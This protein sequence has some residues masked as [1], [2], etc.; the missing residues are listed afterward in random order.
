MKSSF[1]L[2]SLSP[3]NVSIFGDTM[4]QAQLE[5]TSRA[6]RWAAWLEYEGFR[7]LIS[8]GDSTE[9]F[10]KKHCDL[11]TSVPYEQVRAGGQ[12]WQGE[13]AEGEDV[14][15][16]L[17]DLQ[18]TLLYERQLRDETNYFLQYTFFAI[19]PK[20]FNWL[21]YGAKKLFATIL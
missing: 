1:W 7:T 5:T 3:S 2:T 19:Q 18:A 14:S 10:T 11:S 9:F 17:A 12:S 20:S 21:L 16:Q 8:Y 4:C 6:K 13:A 15:K